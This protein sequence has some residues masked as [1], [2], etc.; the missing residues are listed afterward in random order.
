MKADEWPKTLEDDFFVTHVGDGIDQ[1]NAVEWEPNI[2]TFACW[3]V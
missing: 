2:V 1:A 3:N